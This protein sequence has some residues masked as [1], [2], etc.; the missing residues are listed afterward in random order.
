MFKSGEQEHLVIE[1]ETLQDDDQSETEGSTA[2]TKKCRR[3]GRHGRRKGSRAT[4][5]SA[6]TSVPASDSQ[7]SD[8][9]PAMSVLELFGLAVGHGKSPVGSTHRSVVTWND[10]GKEKPP[11]QLD[12]TTMVGRNSPC[13]DGTVFA[14]TVQSPGYT[15]NHFSGG[16][17]RMPATPLNNV[18]CSVSQWTSPP[19]QT[20]LPHNEHQCGNSGYWPIQ[21]SDWAVHQ[22]VQ[23]MTEA[24]VEPNSVPHF[25]YS[26]P[27][28]TVPDEHPDALVDWVCKWR[29]CANSPSSRTGIEEMLRASVPTTYED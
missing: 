6:S 3:R 25:C 2:V 8:D 26:A 5:C 18:N 21:N 12:E 27:V 16:F 29:V 4:V 13:N 20:M 24:F 1:D 15:Q 17:V 9:S 28:K 14:Q 19:P 10:L 7:D 11:Q 23:H 22:P